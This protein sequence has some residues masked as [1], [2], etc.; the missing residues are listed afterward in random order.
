ML[1]SARIK[2]LFREKPIKIRFFGAFSLYFYGLIGKELHETIAIL[3]SKILNNELKEIDFITF[4]EI[5]RNDKISI[6]VL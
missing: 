2:L 5:R 1:I 4:K 6:R 3:K